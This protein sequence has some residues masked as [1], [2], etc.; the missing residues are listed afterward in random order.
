MEYPDKL[1]R[2]L[3]TP[4]REVLVELVITKDNGEIET[5]NAYRVQHDD[6]RGPYKGGLRYHPQVDLDDVRSLASLMTWKTA[7]M[8][9]P[10][11]GAKGGI[12]VDPKTLSE[13]EL[14][15]LTRKLVQSIK[16]VIGPHEDIPAPDMNTDGRVM[17]WFFDEYSK[18]EG[19]SPGVVTG[20]PVHLHGSLGREAA[21]GRGTVFATRELLKHSG[22]GSIAGKSIVVQGFGNV[23]AWAAQIFAEQGATVIAVSDAFGAVRNDKGLDVPA[24]RQH[25]AG[26]GSLDSFQEGSSISK[27]EVLFVPCDVLVPAAIG[28]V[29][30]AENADQL[31]CKFVV[32]AANGPTTPEGDQKLRTRGIVVLP[33]IY[34]N[35]GGVTVSFFE[36][37][38]NLQNFRWEEDDVNAKLDRAMTEAFLQIWAIHQQKRIPLRTAAFVQALQKVTRAHIHRGFD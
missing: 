7:V 5:F 37:V 21:T 13:R 11:G 36:W 24:L 38:Q 28:N 23:G 3:L 6:S 17:S 27:D 4:Q 26:G 14:E 10:F 12:T 8:D 25:L 20:K 31:Q 30:T 16:D 34:T 19:F 22:Q 29:I 33:D 32:E 9:I 15:K 35:G 2:L 18:F 1:Q